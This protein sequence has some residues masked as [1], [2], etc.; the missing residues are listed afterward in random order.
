SFAPRLAYGRYLQDQLIDAD[1][2]IEAAEVVKLTPGAP[3]RLA[4]NDGR[5]LSADAVVLASG[6]P[7][8]GLPDSLERAFAPVLAGGADGRIVLDPWAPGALAALGARRPASVLVIGSGLTG[9]DVALHL[10]A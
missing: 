6:R 10:T 4:L 7:Q 9:I 1:V 3:V 2:R 8:N 5:E